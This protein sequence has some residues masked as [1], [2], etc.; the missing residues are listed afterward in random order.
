MQ[1]VQAHCQHVGG[2]AAQAAGLITA[3]YK[4]RVIKY[5]ESRHSMVFDIRGFATARLTVAGPHWRLNRASMMAHVA[6][7]LAAVVNGPHSA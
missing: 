3:L 6:I 1:V 2:K 7:A 4:D 5:C